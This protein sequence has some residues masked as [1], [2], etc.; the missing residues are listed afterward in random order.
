MQKA[1]IDL[2]QVNTVEILSVSMTFKLFNNSAK[3]LATN[4]STTEPPKNQTTKNDT[5]CADAEDE[6]QPV[7]SG[8]REEL[9]LLNHDFTIQQMV[10]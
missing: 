7:D 2:S 5:E 6:Q 10:R 3:V 1:F 4:E 9:K 8:G